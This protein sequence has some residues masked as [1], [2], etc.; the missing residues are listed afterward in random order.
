MSKIYTRQDINQAVFNLLTRKP[1]ASRPPM[2]S[3]I[4]NEW[5][6]EVINELRSPL[7]IL[8]E[9]LGSESPR[10]IEVD[11]ILSSRDITLEQLI[12]EL[13]YFYFWRTN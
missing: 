6:T 8:A 11:V 5:I 3:R 9:A 4:H 2:F 7:G 10:R 12:E 1:H 13:E